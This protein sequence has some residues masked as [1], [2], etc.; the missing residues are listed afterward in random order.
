MHKCFGRQGAA[1]YAFFAF[2]FAFGGMCAYTVIIGDTVP[3]VLQAILGISSTPPSRLSP[4]TAFFT[5]RRVVI[6]ICSFGIMFPVSVV[7]NISA[8]AKFSIFALVAIILIA[9]VVVIDGSLLDQSLRGSRDTDTFTFL[10]I[11]G[12]SAA[13]YV[14]PTKP[15]IFSLY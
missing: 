8:L 13:M 4:L 3:G 7:R 15:C 14:Y 11:E 6:F 2:F 1:L 5:D 10:K 9:L 12:L